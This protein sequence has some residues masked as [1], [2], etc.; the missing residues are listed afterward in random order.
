MTVDQATIAPIFPLWLILLLFILGLASVI[1][2]FFL[3][4]RR[5][6]HSRALFISI[7]RL[8]TILFLISFALN[9]SLVAKKEYKTSPTMAILLDTSLSMGQPGQKGKASRLDEART[10]LMEGQK[11][12]LKSLSEKYEVKL[13]GLGE[14]LRGERGFERRIEGAQWKEYPRSSLKRW[15]SEMGWQPVESSPLYCSHGGSG[16]V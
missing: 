3:I 8:G 14:P 13:Y 2:Q 5:L 11:P 10:F 1:L 9:P 12:L 4:R 15:K 7:L 16:R 6:G